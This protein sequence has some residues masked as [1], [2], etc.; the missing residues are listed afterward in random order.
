MYGTL[1]LLQLPAVAHAR[2]SLIFR[3]RLQTAVQT[4]ERAAL[5]QNEWNP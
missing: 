2:L 5:I 3:S 4:P 1:A